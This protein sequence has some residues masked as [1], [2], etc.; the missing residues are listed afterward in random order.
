MR[1][2]YLAI[3][4]KIFE[5]VYLFLSYYKNFFFTTGIYIISGTLNVDQNYT[6]FPNILC[7]ARFYSFLPAILN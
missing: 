5:N 1:A 7:N 4:Y 3:N 2:S 6:V